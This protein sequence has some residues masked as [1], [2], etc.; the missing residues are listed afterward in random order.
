[1]IQFFKPRKLGKIKML[2]IYYD[3]IDYAKEQCL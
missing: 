3:L 2:K 1:M